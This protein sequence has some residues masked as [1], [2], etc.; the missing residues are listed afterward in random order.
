MSVPPSTIVDVTSEALEIELTE[1]FGISGGSADV[2]RIAVVSL[3]LA[4]GTIGLGEAAPLP[5]Y[6]GERVPDAL[7]A[8]DAARRLWIGTD[9]RA[10]RRRALELGAATRTS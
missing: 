7:A 10:W 4:D 6:N 9:A 3:R 8:I 1:P 5:A 2:A